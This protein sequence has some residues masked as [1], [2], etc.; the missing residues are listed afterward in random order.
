MTPTLT[1]MSLHEGSRGS[2]HIKNMNLLI[3]RWRGQLGALDP[4]QRLGGKPRRIAAGIAVPTIGLEAALHLAGAHD[5]V[6]AAVDSY[7]LRLKG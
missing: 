2:W 7:P 4:F 3:P 1:I 6:V 5:E